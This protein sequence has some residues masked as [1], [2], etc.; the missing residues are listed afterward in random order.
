[1]P[2]PRFYVLGEHTLGYVYEEQPDLLGVLAG[3]PQLGGHDWKNGPVAFDPAKLRVATVDDFEFFR[4]CHK[5][6]ELG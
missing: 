6:Y 3:K 1:M 5:G 4:V 2:N